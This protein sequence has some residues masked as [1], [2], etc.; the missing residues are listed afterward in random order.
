MY[1]YIYIHIY[2]YT[3]VYIY[4]CSFSLL[5]WNL[6]IF[7]DLSRFWWILPFPE[8]GSASL[9]G[10][11]SGVQRL[12]YRGLWT[13]GVAKCH[14]ALPV[15]GMSP[16]LIFWWFLIMGIIL[17]NYSWTWIITVMIINF[18]CHMGPMPWTIPLGRY[19]QRHEV[20]QLG[21]AYRVYHMKYP[22]LRWTHG[23]CQWDFDIV[24]ENRSVSPTFNGLGVS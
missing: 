20:P 7:L 16:W 21:M 4:I 13:Q 23:D 9:S 2:I 19:T 22:I 10:R 6:V 11:W 5:P 24:E 3:Y 18:G 14:S 8:R 17:V 12:Q 1:I 15:D